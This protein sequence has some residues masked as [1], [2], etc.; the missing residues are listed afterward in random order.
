MTTDERHAT[1]LR[2]RELL[3]VAGMPEPDEVE[4]G[5]ACIWLRW[6]EQQLTVMVD[7]IP[8]GDPAAAAPEPERSDALDIPF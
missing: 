5:E 3:R 1:E 8:V 7:E 4:Y 6:Y 2:M